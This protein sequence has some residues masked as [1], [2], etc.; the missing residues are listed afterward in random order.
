M[1]AARWY[2]N[3]SR[4]SSIYSVSLCQLNRGSANCRCTA[5]RASTAS[6]MWVRFGEAMTARSRS[7]APANISAALANTRAAGY[8]RTAC[9]RRDGFEVTIAEIT[10]PGVAAMT[11]AW[12]AAPP[13]PNP[14][15]PTRQFFSALTGS[16]PLACSIV[17][18]SA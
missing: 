1:A 7:V 15:S 8:L 18:R 2:F 13:R 4:T 10:R 16:S 5:A 9:S 12:K 17:D 14:I 6:G 11:G 3:N